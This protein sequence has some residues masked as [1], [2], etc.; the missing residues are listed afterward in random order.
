M[1]LLREEQRVPPFAEVTA[2]GKAH[3]SGWVDRMFALWL[4]E[5]TGDERRRLHAQLIAICDTY[6]WY[7]L[8]R[9]QGLS[10]AQT[11]LAL[12]EMVTGVVQL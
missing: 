4:D 9:Q 11:E 6:T 8:R 3:H 5:R 2:F 12:V 1:L 10:G 7:L